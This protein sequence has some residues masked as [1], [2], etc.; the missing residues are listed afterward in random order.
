MP[1]RLATNEEDLDSTPAVRRANIVPGGDQ[2]ATKGVET[3]RRSVKLG[4]LVH[5]KCSENCFRRLRVSEDKDRR[6]TFLGAT[7]SGGVDW[8]WTMVVRFGANHLFHGIEPEIASWEMA[9]GGR[10]VR[11]A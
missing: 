11:S 6:K 1:E 4:V 5:V 10:K 7:V 2:T 3:S 9:P 8:R